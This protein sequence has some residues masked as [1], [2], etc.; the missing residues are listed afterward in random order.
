MANSMR[1]NLIGAGRVGQTLG[2]LLAQDGN[3]RLQDV[4]TRGA[5]S[6]AAAV[7]FIGTGRA[8]TQPKD[9]RPTDVWILAVPDGQIA[10]AAQSL[11]AAPVASTSALAFHCSGA[12]CAS[13]LAPLQAK[14][15]QVASAHC[16]L[17][18][19]Q[20]SLALTQF[21]G[22]PCAL[23]GDA[24]ALA[25]LHP[26]FTRLGAHCFELAAADKLLYHAGAVFATNFLPV[27]QDLGEQLWQHAHMPSELAQQLRARLLQNAV[28]NIVQLGP[29]GALTGPAA[30]GDSALV[31]KQAQAVAEWQPQAGEAYRALSA[32]AQ[33]LARRP[34]AASPRS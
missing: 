3:Y 25:I 19:A 6:A 20:P 13:E 17:S 9:L 5:E 14:G 7:A 31:S 23:E 28:N 34:A 29:Q 33:Q 26:L 32:L 27:L 2:R 4:L 10:M 21:A 1:I 15:W 11:A 8:L 12:L 22:T 30:R 18:F 16:L 24:A